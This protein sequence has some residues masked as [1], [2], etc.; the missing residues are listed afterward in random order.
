MQYKNANIV[1]FV[2]AQPLNINKYSVAFKLN[3]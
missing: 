1:N 2:L 3:M